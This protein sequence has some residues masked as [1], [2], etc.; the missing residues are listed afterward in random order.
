MHASAFPFRASDWNA[1]IAIA[2]S[3][4]DASSAPSSFLTVTTT[5]SPRPLHRS[6]TSAQEAI[7]AAEAELAA[8]AAKP[9]KKK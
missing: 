6:P 9:S 5:H 7:A 8:K 3:L 1:R 4:A 2:T